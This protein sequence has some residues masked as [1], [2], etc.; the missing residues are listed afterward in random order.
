M[1]T[2]ESLRTSGARE[3]TWQCEIGYTDEVSQGYEWS[4]EKHRQRVFS[5][6]I[7]CSTSSFFPPSY[8]F[9]ACIE[10]VASFQSVSNLVRSTLHPPS[11]Y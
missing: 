7:V 5:F 4:V 10:V 9:L 2:W 8:V 1:L 3:T 6:P 11:Y